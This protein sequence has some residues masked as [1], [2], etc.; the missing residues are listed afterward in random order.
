MNR[1]KPAICLAHA[2]GA[3]PG[4]LYAAGISAVFDTSADIRAVSGASSGAVNAYL[5][6]TG[7]AR[8]A[9]LIWIHVLEAIQKIV[10]LNPRDW[11]RHHGPFMVQKPVFAAIAEHFDC[12]RFRQAKMPAVIVYTEARGPGIA[13]GNS[14]GFFENLLHPFL[15]VPFIRNGFLKSERMVLNNTM[16]DELDD[17]DILQRVQASCCLPPFYGKPVKNDGA[18]LFDGVLSDDLGGI[19]S[20]M[21]EGGNNV[22]Y[23]VTMRHPRGTSKYLKRRKRLLDLAEKYHLN[24]GRVR[25]LSPD[26][27]LPAVNRYRLDL[28]AFEKCYHTG[29]QDAGRFL[30]AL[31]G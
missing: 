26:K 11:I 1:D 9:L 28:K 2:G 31:P 19:E 7:Q 8:E 14:A 24:A 16:L 10:S 5:T 6:A 12:S 22:W 30:S 21:A 23:L 4:G 18:L 27:P 15:I 25:I 3:F 29:T 13:A 17:G 20:L